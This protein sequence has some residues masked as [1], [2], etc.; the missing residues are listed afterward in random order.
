LAV[1]SFLATDPRAYSTEVAR[2]DDTVNIAAG[3][4]DI[5]GHGFPHAFGGGANGARIAL[6]AGTAD[7]PWRLIVVATTDLDDITIDIGG[8]RLIYT[9][10]LE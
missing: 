5:G 7:A 10:P 9:L 8:R 6:N 1:A 3:G 4:L 2:V